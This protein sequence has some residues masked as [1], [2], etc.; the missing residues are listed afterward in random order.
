[1]AF[2]L[3]LYNRQGLNY[4]DKAVRNNSVSVWHIAIVDV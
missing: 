4:D 1:M 2:A 3:L